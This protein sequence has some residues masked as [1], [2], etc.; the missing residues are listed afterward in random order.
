MVSGS[1]GHVRKGMQRT[2]T[3]ADGLARF[4]LLESVREGVRV[5]EGLQVPPC[6]QPL[7]NGM[8]PIGYA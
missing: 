8:A 7:K 1:K 5:A 6:V 2:C 4:I 3:M